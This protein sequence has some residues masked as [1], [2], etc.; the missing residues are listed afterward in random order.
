GG[1]VFPP[2][3]DSP[4]RRG[5][6]DTRR[7]GHAGHF[8]LPGGAGPAFGTVPAAA[9]GL[10]AALY[11]PPLLPRADPHRSRGP[12][13]S[14]LRG[15][16][17]R[18]G[19]HLRSGRCG[20]PGHHPAWRID[21]RG[22]QNARR[23]ALHRLRL[24][25]WRGQS[26]LSDHRRALLI[27][28][29]F[30]PGSIATQLS[31]PDPKME[32]KPSPSATSH[33][34]HDLQIRLARISALGER[35]AYFWREGVRWRHRSFAQLHGRIHASAARLAKAGAGPE[36]PILIQGP[37][38]PDWVEALLGAFL[39]G[40]ITVPLDEASPEAFRFE[41]ARRS[42]AQFL[43][44]PRGV[45][46]PPGCVHIELGDWPVARPLEPIWEM[47]L[48]AGRPVARSAPV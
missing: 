11:A 31:G 33:P 4:A 15:S 39:L 44:A 46:V 29:P 43:V 48:P 17:P 7:S 27:S 8:L 34:S 35:P 19:Q 40:A 32:P 10:E 18:G 3:H 20:E 16:H 28:A 42:N 25:R 47:A 21:F 2:Q 12:Q 38:G 9:G 6:N 26:H 1:L 30:S 41:V 13:L 23:T 24:R 37:P 5:G 22:S 14:C 45:S 36:S